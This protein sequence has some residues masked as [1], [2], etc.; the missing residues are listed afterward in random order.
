MQVIRHLFVALLAVALSSAAVAQVQQARG[1]ATVT[2]KGK[3]APAD[4]KAQALQKAQLKAVEFY[5]AEAGESEA[6][7]FDAVRDKI[8]ADPDRYILE[9]TVLAEE[10]NPANQQ[11]TVA[12]KISLNVANLR[13]A[14]KANS[15]VGKA[16]RTER[17]ALAF[18]FVSRQVDSV[19]SYDPRQ[20]K[21][22]DSAGK[23]DATA[24]RSQKGV[25]GESIKKGQIS[26]NESVDKKAS[27][28]YNVSET[29]ETGGST[30]LK[31]S[32]S[33]WRLIPSANLNQVFTATFSKAGF[34]VSEAAFIEPYT[35]GQFKVA[36]VEDDYK[37][38]NDLRS[39]TLQSIVSGMRAAQIPFIAFGTLD[40]GLADRDPAS[41]L[42]RV[43]VTVNA[44][45]LDVT[46]PIPDT[47]A[48]VGPV[49]YSGVGPSEEEARTSALKAAANSA[50]RDLTSQLTNLGLR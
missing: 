26:T 50:S 8:V 1:K 6:A 21:R 41:G 35:N 43:A 45:I 12:V 22:V 10:D 2:Y 46:Q 42:Q 5:Y 44:K 14:V 9:T 49:Q 29:T 36:T 34:K 25:E 11:Y 19:K 39:S 33:T 23:A 20:Y 48:S 16:G 28:T 18:L 13:N 24:A 31:A 3:A 17:S 27:A 37:A 4:A 40:V 15:A 30:T 47:I 38:G 7:N 32:D